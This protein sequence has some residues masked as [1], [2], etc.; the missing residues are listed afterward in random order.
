MCSVGLLD[1]V[2][3][4]SSGPWGLGTCVELSTFDFGT[5]TAAFTAGGFISA[6]NAARVIDHWG[7]KRT[8]V[9]GAWLV[10]AVSWVA[11]FGTSRGGRLNERSHCCR[12][13]LS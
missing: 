1:G 3:G 10:I 9:Y 7:K 12:A 8:A 4:S 11:Q 6:L 5:I 13:E 2:F